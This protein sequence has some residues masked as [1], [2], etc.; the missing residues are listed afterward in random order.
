MTEHDES[1]VDQSHLVYS[2]E[3]V[4]SIVGIS[5]AVKPLK[6]TICSRSLTQAIHTIER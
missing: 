6:S 3:P 5:E 4:L 2:R 1:S